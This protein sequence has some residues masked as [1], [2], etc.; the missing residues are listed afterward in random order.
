MM[1][2]SL[3]PDL[4]LPA[5]Q[6]DVLAGYSHILMCLKDFLAKGEVFIL[7]MKLCHNQLHLSV[8]AY[9]CNGSRDFKSSAA[10]LVPRLAALKVFP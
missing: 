2:L 4:T 10:A 5:E 1:Y 8:C 7:L 9:L 6:W 3:V